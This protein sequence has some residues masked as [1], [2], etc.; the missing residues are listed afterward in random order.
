MNSETQSSM[1]G[2]NTPDSGRG[3]ERPSWL[4]IALVA[5]AVILLGRTFVTR[6][7]F[8]H[9]TA[10][11]QSASS[12]P[13]HITPRGPLSKAEQS[14]ID[15]FRRAAPSVAFVKASAMGRTLFDPNPL[16]IPQGTGSC[17][18]WDQQGH[19]VTNYH[20]VHK[21]SRLQVIL[22]DQ[23]SW[24][25]ELVGIAPSKDLAVLR[26]DAPSELLQ[27]ISIGTSHDLIVG[28]SVMAIGSPFGLDQTLTTGV[29]SGLDREIKAVNKRRISG[30]IQTDTAIN[31]GNS[32]GPLLDSSGRLVGVNTAIVSPS[33]A[34]AGI[35]FAI[36]VDTVNRIVPQ[37][38]R[39][40]RVVRPYLGV[41]LASPRILAR[42][43]VDGVLV[44]SVEDGTAAARAGLRPTIIDEDIQLG[45]III[46]MDGKAIKSQD[47][48]FDVLE[49]KQVGDLVEIKVLRA[50]RDGSVK[51]S[52]LTAQLGTEV[53]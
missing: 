31:P 39:H 40:G 52:L 24:S 50:Q 46:E 14:T 42:M 6:G 19:I 51:K 29:V 17:F 35:G 27:P 16:E 15:V 25:A 4:V 38:I 5:M 21:A 41:R 12:E 10:W 30:V 32:G 8:D 22:A 37:L 11:A 43:N 49:S 2:P 53:E 1:T 47:D 34:Y 33:G 36:P 7:L 45:D 20:V 26:I 23:S 18:I 28:Q 13:R 9:A 48:L 3:S 44:Q